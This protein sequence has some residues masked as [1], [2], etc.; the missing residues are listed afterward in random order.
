MG[1]MMRNTA[2]S[3]TCKPNRKDDQAHNTMH[4][5]NWVKLCRESR[6]LTKAGN[7][8]VRVM[9]AVVSGDMLGSIVWVMSYTSTPVM[10]ATTEEESSRSSCLPV[11]TSSLSA[12]LYT[13]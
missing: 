5:R 1:R 9:T 10:E 13:A 7:I 11:T 6:S 8:Q 2:F 3:W 4:L 12:M